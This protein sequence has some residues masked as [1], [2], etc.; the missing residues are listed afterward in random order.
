VSSPS[1]PAQRRVCV[2]LP[3][4]N[5]RATVGGVVR[6]VLAAVPAG[7]GVLVVDD[8]STDGAEEV[9]GQ[10]PEIQVVIHEQNQGKGAALATG[11]GRAA[12]LGFSHAITMDAD[13]Q[14]SASDL[15]KFL[16]AVEERP[17]AL[18]VGVRDLVGA[19]ARR[20]SR[21]LR[22]HSNFWVWFHTGQWVH[23]TQSGFRA[24]PLAPILALRLKTRRYDFEVEAVVKAL[25]SGV[26]LVEVPVEVRYGTGSP[27]H[28]RPV[29]D[30]ALV[31]H[32][33]GFLF[34]QRVLL[35]ASVRRVYHLKSFHE[36]P[37]L[38]R[39]LE[40]ARGAVFQETVTAAGF[41]L[42]MGT[43][44]FFGILPIWGF[45]MAAA[46]VVAHRL[47]LS[48]PLVLAA[49][50]VSF[51]V[52]IPLILWLSLLVGHFVFTGSLALNLSFH[53]LTRARA[54]SYAGQYLVGAVILAAAAGLAATA[55]S[56][57]L[58]RVVLLVRG[59]RRA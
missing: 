39:G 48:K 51:P 35:P 16:A 47:R 22:A 31:C 59:R 36:G 1:A 50:N 43:G 40:V 23:D 8:G 21:L 53:G 33:N 2:V 12:E 32:L 26:P 13:G 6:E 3:T 27:S 58:A 42:C 28:F 46:V 5:N 17:D 20:R 45:Q 18:V 54:W 34:W 29:R 9:L 7:V 19:G 10:F 55:V 30:F 57:L 15:A 56:Y 37:W 49:S 14:H 25:W 44:V 41:A 52:L 24:Y 11:L 4:Y 38:R